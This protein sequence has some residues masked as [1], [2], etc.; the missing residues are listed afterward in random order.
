MKKKNL[1]LCTHNSSRSQMAEG[2]LRAMYGN[3]YE[4]YSAGVVATSVDPRA[5]RVMLEI[6][7]D[8]SAQ[9]SKSSQEFLGT[10]FDLAVTVC[11]RAK[12]TCPICSTQLER[13][14]N[15][16]R[17]REVIHKSFADPAASAGSEEEQL[18]AFRQV[19]DEIKEWITQTFGR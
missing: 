18:E 2:L 10:I 4:A 12:E 13:P 7:I 16:P 5:V 9:R 19:R 14:S 11:D 15:N 17:A 8:I 1:F 6:G 3:R